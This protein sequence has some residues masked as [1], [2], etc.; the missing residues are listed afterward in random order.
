MDS[1]EIDFEVWPRYRQADPG[2]PGCMQL[3]ERLEILPSCSIL[4]TH[5]PLFIL[6]SVASVRLP[7]VEQATAWYPKG[8]NDF[9]PQTQH[10]STEDPV[11]L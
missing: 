5:A 1:G 8:S 2:N 10:S 3:H 9:S 7:S 4:Q 11:I 6:Y